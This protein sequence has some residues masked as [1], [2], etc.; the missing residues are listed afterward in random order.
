MNNVISKTIIPVMHCFNDAYSVPAAVAFYSML[1]CASP[2]FYYKFYVLHS[3]I[4]EEN[5]RKLNLIV[6]SFANADL[7]FINVKNKFSNLFE[8]TNS[9]GH[10]SEEMYYKFLAPEMFP[11]YDKII[12]TD[13]DVC[14]TGDISKDFCEQNTDE[15]FYIAGVKTLKPDSEIRG[16]LLKNCADAYLKEFTEDERKKLNIGAGYMIFNLKNMR[17]NNLQKEFINFA[18]KNYF[19]LKQPEQDVLNIVC[20]PKIKF[21]KARAMVCTYLYDIYKTEADYKY[22]LRYT[23]DEVKNTLENPI[24]IHYATNRKPWNSITH[25][26]LIW[27]SY[28]ISASKIVQKASGSSLS[29]PL[30]D[31]VM[32]FQK[33]YQLQ[34][35][36]RKRNR[37]FSFKL[38]Y[39]R[40]KFS[41]IKEKV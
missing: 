6:S 31:F 11:Q 28:L 35:Q 20:S 5:Q 29:T 8:R 16:E 37:V 26:N 27:F 1:K 7:E 33:T 21:L 12:I 17:K 3:D 4:T 10:Y 2:D 23:E 40:Y 22:D 30:S 24:Q 38:P 15:D 36:Q 14:Y 34:Q 13:V 9:K 25:K 19:R 18:N 41:F 32:S 39:I